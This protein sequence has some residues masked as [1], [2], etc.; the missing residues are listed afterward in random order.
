MIKRRL[1]PVPH[2]NG[3]TTP[4]AANCLDIFELDSG[5][6]AMI[7]INISTQRAFGSWPREKGNPENT[8]SVRKSGLGFGIPNDL[9]A[10]VSHLG[11]ETQNHEKQCFAPPARTC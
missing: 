3:L 11:R 7:G 8:F 6:F 10:S 2:A 5:D 9:C 1:G 4:A